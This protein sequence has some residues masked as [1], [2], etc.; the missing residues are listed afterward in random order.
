MPSDVEVVESQD[1]V[2]RKCWEKVICRELGTPDTYQKVAVLIIRWDD[3]L[4]ADLKAK[5][6]VSGSHNPVKLH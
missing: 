5:N 6:E 3:S 4:D 1:G 2:M